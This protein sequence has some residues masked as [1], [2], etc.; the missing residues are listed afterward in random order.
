LKGNLDAAFVT[1]Q[2]FSYGTLTEIYRQRVFM[3]FFN[4]IESLFQSSLGF[5]PGFHFLF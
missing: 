2:A 3:R 1:L 4:A 5:F